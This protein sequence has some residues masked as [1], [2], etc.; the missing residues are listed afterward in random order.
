MMAVPAREPAFA[1]ALKAGVPDLLLRG[2]LSMTIM[3]GAHGPQSPDIE[4]IQDGASARAFAGAGRCEERPA[5]R[6]R[7]IRLCASE[8]QPP[9]GE[10]GAPRVPS[11]EPGPEG[12]Y[13]GGL[14]PTMRTRTYE[15][16]VADLRGEA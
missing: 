12:C 13:A 7:A 15:R 8:P 4:I 10:R 5:R 3:A 9:R 11:L 14:V 2:G 16:C 6:E 1:L